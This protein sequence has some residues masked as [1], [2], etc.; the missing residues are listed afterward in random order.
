MDTHNKVNLERTKNQLEQ[1]NLDIEST[2]YQAYNDAKNAKN[3]MNE[4]MWRMFGISDVC[5]LYEHSPE[6]DKSTGPKERIAHVGQNYITEKR[7]LQFKILT[8]NRNYLPYTD[9]IIKK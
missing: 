1:T 6:H 4:N 2:V 7:K 9:N 3:S 5:I 8:N